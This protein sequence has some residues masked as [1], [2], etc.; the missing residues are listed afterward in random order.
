[1]KYAVLYAHLIDDMDK[2]AAAP[3]DYCE[4]SSGTI[5]NP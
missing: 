4:P 1:M 5:I 2:H 3:G